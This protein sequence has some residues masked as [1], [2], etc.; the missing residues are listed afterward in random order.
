MAWPTVLNADPVS[1]SLSVTVY[2]H[3]GGR[4]SVVRHR[5]ARGAFLHSRSSTAHS[6]GFVHRHQRDVHQR[7]I[8]TLPIGARA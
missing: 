3:A 7:L 5:L 1:P 2:L 4:F 6:D 8:L